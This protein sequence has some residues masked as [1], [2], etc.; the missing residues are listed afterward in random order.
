MKRLFYLY[1]FWFAALLF[2]ILIIPASKEEKIPKEP[3]VIKYLDLIDMIEQNAGTIRV[4]LKTTDYEG[5][6]HEK[7][8]LFYDNQKLVFDM[9]CCEEYIRIEPIERGILI[10]S[11]ERTQGNPTY[12]G[13]LDIYKTEQGF[14][15]INELSMEEYLCSVVPSEMPSSYPAEAL[16]AQA[17]CARTYASRYYN[18]MGYPEY[19]A[20]VDDSVM[21]QVY[22]NIATSPE[23]IAAVE[24]SSGLI[25]CDA[26]NNLADTF[27][28]STGKSEFEKEEPWYAWEYTVEN[29]QPEIMSEQLKKV[30]DVVEP[31]TEVR[32]LEIVERG[33]G[34]VAYELLVE[35]DTGEYHVFS[36][37]NIRTA[38]CNG[39]SDALKQ[40]G[41]TYYCKSLIPSGFI[42]MDLVWEDEAVAGYKITG[43]GFG[44]GNGMSQNG[45][46]N[47]AI[48][49][50]RTEEIL[51][52]Y[53]P[54]CHIDT[55][56]EG[57]E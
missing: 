35:T 12:L 46:K 17:I 28:Y 54:G 9:A 43:N 36:E 53:Y 42:H 41:S 34:D 16:K 45:A 6:Y 51:N 8:E 40:D 7:V 57:E 15:I 49:G 2:L 10:K 50:L 30:V 33:T 37:Y 26:A 39:E 52:Y 38:L 20:H 11:I 56:Y 19:N 1:I 21:F 22:N 25:L 4:L 3:S 5:I 24:E 18:Q 44:H 31:F 55:L 29:L 14:V 32:N 27:Y 47:M 23:A 13:V 48:Q